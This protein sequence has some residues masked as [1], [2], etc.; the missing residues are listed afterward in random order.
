MLIKF[1]I[2]KLNK[3]TLNYG[4]KIIISTETEWLMIM[5]SE[6]C[7]SAWRSL[8]AETILL[9]YSA[10]KYNPDRCSSY[11]NGGGPKNIGEFAIG[12]AICT[13]A[14]LGDKLGVNEPG[15]IVGVKGDILGKGL[16]K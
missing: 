13:E 4:D 15:N 1:T 6:I 5:I 12:L 11:L 8:E 14:T 2:S 9:E 3:S 16:E 7:P 10:T